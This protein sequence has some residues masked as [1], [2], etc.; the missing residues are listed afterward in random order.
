MFADAESGDGAANG[1]IGGGLLVDFI[2]SGP[3]SKGDNSPRGKFCD[4]AI[5][6]FDEEFGE[7]LGELVDFV[8]FGIFVEGGVIFIE[9]GFVGDD[10][11]RKTEQVELFVGEETTDATVAVAE[12]VDILELGVEMGDFFE[13]VGFVVSIVIC[14]E[15][16]H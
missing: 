10:D 4:T 9:L 5:E 2:I 3:I 7:E 11:G 6:G 15:F 14:D 12:G 8:C 16:V 13:E 1:L